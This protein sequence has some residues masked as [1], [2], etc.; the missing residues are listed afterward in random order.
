MGATKGLITKCKMVQAENPSVFCLDIDPGVSSDSEDDDDTA[1]FYASNSADAAVPGAPTATSGE[2]ATP[3]GLGDPSA[4]DDEGDGSD[5]SGGCNCE[6]HCPSAGTEDKR[7][8][9]RKR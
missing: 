7:L 4:R 2:V 1:C 9:F 8:R 3:F 6:A 5:R